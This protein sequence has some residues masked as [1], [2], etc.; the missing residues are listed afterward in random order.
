MASHSNFLS[1]SSRRERADAP[2]WAAALRAAI[3]A[4]AVISCWEDGSL[5][6][7][8]VGS[9]GSGCCSMIFVNRQKV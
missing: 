6:L 3:S 8:L 9:L 4:A 2:A 1:Q 5:G 7:A